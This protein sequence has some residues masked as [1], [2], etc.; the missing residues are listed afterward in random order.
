MCG[1]GGVL[2]KGKNGPVGDDLRQLVYGI[3]HRGEDSSGVAVFSA[4]EHRGDG[5]ELILNVRVD[6]DGCQSSTETLDI[7]RK[8]LTAAGGRVIDAQVSGTIMSIRVL[9]GGSV[10]E[11]CYL[12]DQNNVQT[13]S[14][15]TQLRIYKDLGTSDRLDEA[16]HYSGLAGTHG[17]GHARLATESVV[18]PDRAHPFWAYGFK[19][20]AIV[21]NGQLTN[22]W[23]LRRRFERWGYRFRTDNDSE[24]IAIYAAHYLKQGLDL[25]GVLEQSLADLDGTYT[26]LVATPTEI[27]FAKD[28][29]AAKPLVYVELEDRVVLAS[30]EIS[31]RAL[32][33]DEAGYAVEEPPPYIAGTWNV[34]GGRSMKKL[35]YQAVGLE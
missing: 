10:Q 24:L 5:E 13:I 3:R 25:Q 34:S 18:S 17:I 20:V 14:V 12:L 1:I 28:K 16:Y 21:H 6:I 35:T 22:Y 4:Q 11:L 2:Y 33:P 23:K 27:G 19:D 9:Y 26:F 15:G 8:L 32:L 31:L 7:M 30:E 29:L